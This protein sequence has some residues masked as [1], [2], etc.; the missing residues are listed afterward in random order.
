MTPIEQHL[1]LLKSIYPEAVLVRL[2]SGAHLVTIPNVRIPVGWSQEIVT[3]LF[4][5]PPGYPGAQPD[6]FWVEPTGLRLVTGQ[7]PQGTNDSNA[8]PEVGQRGTWFSWHVQHWN[9]NHD[10]LVT[11]T[12]VVMRRFQSLQ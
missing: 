4:V 1:E 12:N 2:P 9:P 8:I 7:T 3:L 11:F 6:C 5:A 10:S